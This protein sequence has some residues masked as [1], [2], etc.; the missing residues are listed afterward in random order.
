[1]DDDLELLS[2]TRRSY[3]GSTL[4]PL[5]L[6]ISQEV[7][8]HFH[9]NNNTNKPEQDLI[10]DYMLSWLETH[11]NI[12]FKQH[13]RALVENRALRKSFGMIQQAL[14]E[15]ALSCSTVDDLERSSSST[16]GQDSISSESEASD[17][18]DNECENVTEKLLR[19]GI[20]NRRSPKTWW[21][22]SSE[23][24][25]DNVQYSNS[26]HNTYHEFCHLNLLK[27]IFFRK[28]LRGV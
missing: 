4:L 16:S 13:E 9:K 3:V 15:L 23:T 6:G 28:L 8:S 10:I 7:L 24:N 17:H 2:P 26:L 22:S 18:E 5:L 1:M 12:R 21:N 19:L 20:M 27:N 25:G 14:L 11:P